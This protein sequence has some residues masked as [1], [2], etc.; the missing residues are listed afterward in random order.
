L[1][2]FVIFSIYDVS[3]FKENDKKRRNKKNE[4]EELFAKYFTK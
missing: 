1:T 2:F 3:L 4:E